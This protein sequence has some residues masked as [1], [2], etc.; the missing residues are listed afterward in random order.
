MTTSE[1]KAQPNIIP[2]YRAVIINGRAYDKV[3][4]WGSAAGDAC[5][6]TLPHY[7]TDRRHWI[8]FSDNIAPQR[9]T[10]R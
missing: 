9:R 8:V 6:V 4:L 2:L 7:N 5:C 1:R 3:K 10:R